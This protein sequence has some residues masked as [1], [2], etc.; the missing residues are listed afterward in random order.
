ME[1][2][3]GLGGARQT[4]ALL[5]TTPALCIVVS[6]GVPPVAELKIWWQ[7]AKHLDA[8]GLCAVPELPLVH[9]QYQ[10][11]PATWFR[12]DVL[13]IVPWRGSRCHITV[14]A[15]CATGR[16]LCSCV[17]I[18]FYRDVTGINPV[19]E[20]GRGMQSRMELRG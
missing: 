10:E 1:G 12:W 2:R 3:A 15:E 7:V 9:G 20:S 19:N 13:R 8:T 11:N 17:H 16:T 14:C 5:S 18:E 4:C 6:T